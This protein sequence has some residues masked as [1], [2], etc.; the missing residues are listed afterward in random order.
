MYTWAHTGVARGLQT[1]RL[2]ESPTQQQRPH[3]G[4]REPGKV[5]RCDPRGTAG[6][7]KV[8]HGPAAVLRPRLPSHGLH[9][10]L[11]SFVC[12]WPLNGPLAH[13][14][15][16]YD[17]PPSPPAPAVAAP[18]AEPPQSPSGLGKHRR[19]H[20]H[21][22]AAGGP[23]P[24]T[25]TSSFRYGAIVPGGKAFF[26][27]FGAADLWG[28]GAVAPKSKL[29]LLTTVNPTPGGAASTGP[30]KQLWIAIRLL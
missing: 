21:K 3:F 17:A 9:R 22:A 18:T 23:C 14:A 16:S 28:K 10:L 24:R 13:C 30:K 25:Q 26:G 29:A 27:A 15:A 5:P 6:P 7:Q 11:R 20:R 12:D 4:Q 19:H 8:R 2:C 1:L